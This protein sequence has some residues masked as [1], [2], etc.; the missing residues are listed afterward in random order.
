V[1][2]SGIDCADG[3]TVYCVADVWWHGGLVGGIS[4]VIQI[5]QLD[6]AQCPRPETQ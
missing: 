2:G 4:T 5:T 1:Y 6:D 3:T